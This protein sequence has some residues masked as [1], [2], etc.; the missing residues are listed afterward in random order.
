MENRSFSDASEALAAIDDARSNAADRLVTPGWYH[1]VLGLLAAVFVV[2]Y[3]TG[4]TVIM[5]SVAVAYFLGLGL[6][7]AAYKEKTGLWVNGLKAGK[8]SWWTVPLV[9][10]LILCAGAAYYFH[11]EK[12]LDWPAWVAGIVVFVAVNVFGRRFDNALRA[13]LRGKP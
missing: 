8:A 5:I 7:M 6:L 1:P 4:G 11:A 10:I 13:Q 9:L 3:T 2:A 12:G